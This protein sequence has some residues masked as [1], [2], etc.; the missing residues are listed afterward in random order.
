[1]AKKLGKAAAMAA[2]LGGAALLAKRGKGE[3]KSA[4][5]ADK[6]A[7]KT[8]NSMM[9]ELE[10]MDRSTRRGDNSMMDEL[11]G[12]PRT[13][14]ETYKAARGANREKFSFRGRPGEYSTATRAQARELAPVDEG[15][16]GIGERMVGAK[17]GGKVKAK[18]K[19]KKYAGG[20]SVG[21]ASKRADGCAVRGKTKGRMV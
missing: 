11:E 17:K 12:M 20:G 6:K 8:D 2:L 1:M 15:S 4:V 18:P 10:G 7:E 9:D 3:E 5:A 14:G 19:T 16:G 13:F 21:S